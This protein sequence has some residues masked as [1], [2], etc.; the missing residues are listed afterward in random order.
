MQ[1]FLLLFK[2]ILIKENN[3]YINLCGSLALRL[4]KQ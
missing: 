2:D 4:L 3:F 1:S